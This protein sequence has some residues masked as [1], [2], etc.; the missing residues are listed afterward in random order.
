LVL[1]PKQHR[2]RLSS[3]FFLHWL[4]ESINNLLPTARVGGDIVVVRVAAMWGM[5][6]RIATAAIIVDV[7]IGVV[8]RVIFVVTARILFVAATGRTDLARPALV[9]VLTGTLAATGFYVVQRMG[10]FRWSARLASRLAKAPSGD[11]LV[12]G[13]EALDQTIRLLYAS[14]R[15]VAR[16]YFFWA[17]SW[18]IASGELWI[19]LRALGSPSSF[20]TAVILESAALAIRGAA[21]LV[22]GALGVQEGGFV[23]LG[24]LL[25]VPGEIALAL[26]L[27]RRVRELALGIPGLVA[28]QLIEAGHLWRGRQL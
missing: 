28:W 16:C 17:V 4:C 10:I 20:T 7:T 8:S 18:I 24:N 26:S 19:A 14:R 6:L 13:G 27:V 11:S 22:P 2:V 12:Q 23:L 21:F 3:S 1:I 15:G 25:G 9:A 5:P